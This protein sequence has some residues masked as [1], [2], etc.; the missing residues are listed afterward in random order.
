MQKRTLA[1]GASVGLVLLVGVAV[2]WTGR[3]CAPSEA[4]ATATAPSVTSASAPTP[5]AP[6]PAA[7]RP[8][9]PE[10]QAF[11]AWVE[12]ALAAIAKKPGPTAGT[13][14]HPV[15][16]PVKCRAPLEPASVRLCT[17]TKIVQ[18][19]RTTSVYSAKWKQD[20]PSVWT[21]AT[22]TRHAPSLDCN[23]LASGSGSTIGRFRDA[24][25]TRLHCR[26]SP[27]R[28]ALIS[29]YSSA[30]THR[31]TNLVYFSPS[32]PAHQPGFQRLLSPGP[33]R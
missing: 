21:V 26:L 33:H 17:S 4:T 10:L 9:S 5:S 1:I 13:T 11:D 15:L 27:S 3:S 8:L 24:S 25:G 7:G 29:Q 20:D 32:F 18:R 19:G 12:G 31:K 22:T 2:L 16:G 23:R 28:E 30:A 14:P 6:G